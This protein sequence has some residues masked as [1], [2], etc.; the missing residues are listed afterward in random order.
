MSPIYQGH[1][2]NKFSL[3]EILKLVFKDNQAENS[4][5]L[6]GAR[7]SKRREFMIVYSSFQAD[8]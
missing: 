5:F 4:I 8:G 2:T 6:F 3:T 7:S 1:A